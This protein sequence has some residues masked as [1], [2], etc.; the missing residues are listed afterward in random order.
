M[1][2]D[3]FQIEFDEQGNIVHDVYN[4][5]LIKLIHNFNKVEFWIES[6]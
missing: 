5:Y 3:K 2:K 6:L 4:S 1:A